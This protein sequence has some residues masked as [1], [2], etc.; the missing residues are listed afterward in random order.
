MYV[1]DEQGRCA[2]V[3]DALLEYTGYG[4]EQI[5][6]RGVGEFIDESAYETAT[7]TIERLYE[8]H[9]G[10]RDAFEVTIRGADGE[11]RISEAHVTV[12]T[13]DTDEYAGS[14]GVLPEMSRAQGTHPGTRPVRGDRRDRPVGLFVV[15]ED[16]SLPLAQRGVHD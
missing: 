7:T 11:T 3:N 14:V 4:R 10:S 9:N 13:T 6:G 5:E 16:G 8:Q 12:I 15:D 2:V 1:L